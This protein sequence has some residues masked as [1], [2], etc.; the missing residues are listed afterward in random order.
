METIEID[1]ALTRI[2]ELLE[3]ASSGVEILITRDRQPMVKLVSTATPPTRPPLFGSDRSI[4]SL[5]DDFD[6][7]LTEFQD[8]V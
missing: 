4:L 1:V 6:A 7:P 2:Q 5:S 3:L 8:Y